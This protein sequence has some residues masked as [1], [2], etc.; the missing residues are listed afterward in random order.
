MDGKTKIIAALWFFQVANYL[1]RVAISFAGPS[2]MAD[3]SLDLARFGV[4]LSCFGIGYFL[5]QVP[6]GLLADRWGAKPLLIIAP[7]FWALFTGMTGL[8][9]GVAG[10]IAVRTC[11]GL[12]EGISN[13]CCYKVIGDHFDA[14]RRARA[15]G[16]W[17]TAFAVGPAFAGPLVSALLAAHG[18]RSVFFLMAAPALVAALVNARYIPARRAERT[19][20]VPAG[21]EGSFAAALRQPALWLMSIVYF[22]FNIAYW[23]YLSWM[24]SYLAQAHHVDIKALGLVGG[25]PYIAALGGLLLAGWLA[26]G[27]CL[28]HRAPLLLGSYLSAG[29]FLYLAYE[30]PSLP[31]SLAGLSGAAFFLYG[32]LSPFGAIVLDLAPARCRAAYAGIVNTAG[33]VGGATAPVVVG[34][35]VGV[36]GNFSSGFGLMIGSLVLAAAG[37]LGATRLTATPSG[38]ALPAR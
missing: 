19:G 31:L 4:V 35:L 29:A 7:L 32:G 1:D 28:R 26:S 36:S 18:W 15:I 37:L 20:I 11:F 34:F 27:P 22:A 33:Q 21:A 10:F 30:A 9:A 24:P 3:L 16:F 6:G 38:S 23:G 17:A 2:I 13:A 5:A 8:V 14:E 12:S 25:I